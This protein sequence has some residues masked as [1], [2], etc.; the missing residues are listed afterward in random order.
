MAI[1]LNRGEK[2]SPILHTSGQ[3]LSFISQTIVWW[4]KSDSTDRNPQMRKPL[5][6]GS[7][8][9]ALRARLE[10]PNAR[11]QEE[12]E[13]LSEALQSK[14]GD[15]LEFDPEDRRPRKRRRS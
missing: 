13:Y 7:Q 1:G 10:Q 2:S 11:E 3:K 12:Q 6:S 15:D 14:R 5:A 9:V 8:W 4:S